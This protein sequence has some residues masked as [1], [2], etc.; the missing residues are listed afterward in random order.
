LNPL[1][2][3]STMYK[4]TYES[5]YENQIV[6]YQMGKVAS[7][8]LYKALKEKGITVDQTHTLLGN[9]QGKYFIKTKFSTLIFLKFRIKDFIRLRA[10][11]KKKEVKVISIVREPISRNISAFFQKAKFID[12]FHNI[13]NTGALEKTFYDKT[14]HK[15]PLKWFDKEF[16]KA[17]G[18]DVYKYQFPK[19]KGYTIIKQNNVKVF[20][21]RFE[22]LNK[23]LK[24]LSNFLNIGKLELVS[25]NVG[26]DK[27]YSEMYKRFKRN[28]KPTEE[29]LNIMYDS[30]YIKHFYT[31]K[32][33]ES[34]KNKWLGNEE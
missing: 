4:S 16:K 26:T 14:T 23:C 10:Y 29:Y 30:K 13:E 1:K 32:E 2:K 28:F 27:W 25:S 6:I 21:F 18:I 33:I 7:T 34:F 11:K 31:D 20:L 9:Y 5:T 17:L 8:T 15:T 12:N 24:P 3:I 19:E 22:D